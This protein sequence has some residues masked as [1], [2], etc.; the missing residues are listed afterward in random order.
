MPLLGIW[1]RRF[2]QGHWY[3]DGDL[4]K[5]VGVCGVTLLKIEL[6]LSKV[7]N[8]DWKAIS[9]GKR[10]QVLVYDDTASESASP[11]RAI[12]GIFSLAW[13]LGMADLRVEV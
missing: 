4:H 10:P 7:A 8:I 6:A 3:I 12:A 11:E 13:I 5:V 2:L 9:G 1:D